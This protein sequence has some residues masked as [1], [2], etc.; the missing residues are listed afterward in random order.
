MHPAKTG[1]TDSLAFGGGLPGTW[2]KLATF[3]SWYLFNSV[4]FQNADLTTY[5]CH[6][7]G[8]LSKQVP[9]VS[10]AV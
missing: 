8:Q 10:S 7:S 3:N 1:L 5:G 2:E 4:A 9:V 6:G